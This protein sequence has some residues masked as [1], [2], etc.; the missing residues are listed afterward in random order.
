MLRLLRILALGGV[1][2][3]SL[4]SAFGFSL[5]GPINERYQVPVIGYNLP[6]DINAPKNLGE[7]YRRNTPV[8]YYSYDANFYNYF[9][10]SGV[11]A[12][13][14]AFSLYNTLSNV[15]SYSSDLH[16]FPLY[17]Q[18]RNWKAE[19]L[20]MIDIKTVTEQLIT[21]QLGLTQPTRYVWTLHDRWLPAGAPPCPFGEE[22]LV[23]KRN[24]DPAYG[25]SLD[26]L[27]PTS[28]INGILY[29]YEIIEFCTGPNPL[30]LAAPF[31]VD[32]VAELEGGTAIAD[33][34]GFG[35]TFL[36]N[37]FGTFYNGLTRD[38]VGGLRY[39]LRTNNVNLESAGPNAFVHLTNTTPT[40]LVTSNLTLLAEQAFTN[41][42]PT[43]IG[44]FPNLNIL[45]TSNFFSN[46]YITNLSGYFTN[47][48]WDPIGT[49][50]HLVFTT[51][52]TP[53]VGTFYQHTF[54]NV[55]TVS[56]TPTG[57]A[58]L[59]LTTIPPP[60][61]AWVTIQT[62]S[63]ATSNNPWA[64]AGSLRIDTNTTIQTYQTNLVIGDYFFLPTNA[65][66][67]AI[68]YPQLTNVLAF[69]NVLFT[70]TNTAIVTNAAG[71]T[72]AGTVLSYTQSIVTYFTNHAFVIYPINCLQS[73]VAL[74]QGIEKISFIPRP[75]DSLLGRFFNPITNEYV[76]NSITNYA[77]LPQRVQRI[78]T[79]PD[80]LCTANDRATAPG[81]P[82][83]GADLGTHSISFN[84]NSENTLLAGPGTIEPAGPGGTVPTA[85]F[86]Y[87]N[88]GP[89]YFNAGLIDTNAFLDE[90]TQ[91]P[92][93]IWGSFDGTTNAPTIYPNDLSVNGLEDQMLIQ[94]LPVWL[95][96]ATVGV[97]YSGV[98][99]VHPSTPNFTAPYNWSLTPGSPALPPGL[100]IGTQ[101]DGTGL[102][103][104]QPMVN[105]FYDFI[106]RITDAQGR[107]VDRAYSI[108]VV[109]PP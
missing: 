15:S 82:T 31:P 91:I 49:P 40:L 25:T 33:F 73:N 59:P 39:L 77:I 98:L 13:N 34:F 36:A 18:R 26:Q 64:P 84:T 53:T 50:A 17:T 72:N 43:L 42:A 80:I 20:F 44:L 11:D 87:G 3:G 79:V 8:L 4:P 94:V 21:E 9:G 81:D 7:E 100:V 29:S 23:I 62:T 28:Y 68:L 102:I 109:P 32:P 104:G 58:V 27:K 93:Y 95:P 30:G 65:C 61:S 60:K 12:L 97:S 14:Q 96:Q 85:I 75:F 69:T 52:V 76:L 105:G 70:L 86:G 55:F 89:I 74:Y 41:D 103:A 24:F 47:Y 83:H 10:Q 108:K 66:E 90:T 37:P 67:V 48:P 46:V 107:T 57:W 45:A 1:L 71:G 106:V 78:V 35:I 19:A 88:Q 101:S 6:G 56:N 99:T 38:D 16:E 22:Y 5:G 2:A 92:I 63:V 54:G 51:N